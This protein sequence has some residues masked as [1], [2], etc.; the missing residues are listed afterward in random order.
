[1]VDFYVDAGQ[2]LGSIRT[3]NLHLL[4]EIH[5]TAEGGKHGIKFSQLIRKLFN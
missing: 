2:S 4:A 1:M 5:P 3:G